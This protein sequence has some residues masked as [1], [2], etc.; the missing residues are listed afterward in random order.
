MSTQYIDFEGSL[1]NPD[2]VYQIDRVTNTVT[3]TIVLTGMGAGTIFTTDFVFGSEAAAI[4]ALAAYVAE[5]ANGG[6]ISRNDL[7]EA[8]ASGVLANSDLT[9]GF[10][11]T[12][13]VPE[14]VKEV[15][16]AVFIFR[17]AEAIK[18]AADF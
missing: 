9:K 11:K 2:L 10:E 5:A 12:A 7:I 15:R 17:V 13:G 8:V 4:L 14:N 18:A 6:R 16:I 1:I 3:F